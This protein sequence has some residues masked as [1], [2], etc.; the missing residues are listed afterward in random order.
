M[1]WMAFSAMVVSVRCYDS[2]PPWIAWQ[3]EFSH[4]KAY[5]WSQESPS[6]HHNPVWGCYSIYQP[7][8]SIVA[9]KDWTWATIVAATTTTTQHPPVCNKALK[10]RPTIH[11]TFP[12]IIWFRTFPS[13]GGAEAQSVD[14][15][16][17]GGIRGQ[18][19]QC[20]YVRRRRRRV[21]R[22]EDK[23]GVRI[24]ESLCVSSGT[25]NFCKVRNSWNQK[26][27]YR[28]SGWGGG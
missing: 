25:W 19:I 18:I 26:R 15:P 3:W 7:P 24:T 1:R 13:G 4:Y 11:N 8:P 27:V 21:G 23:S 16:L 2:R 9:D 12:G 22:R 10:T 5:K 28:G 6:S 17:G 14:R 20:D